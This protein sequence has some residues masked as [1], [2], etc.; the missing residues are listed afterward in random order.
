MTLRSYVRLVI[1]DY[2]LGGIAEC[3]TAYCDT[4]LRSV[5]SVGL[6][7]VTFVRPILKVFAGFGCHLV[8]DS[9]NALCQ[10]W[11][12]MCKKFIAASFYW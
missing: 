5:S 8:Q 12:K 3:D 7:S 11:V 9:N 4:F 1:N 10:M 2:F 6:S